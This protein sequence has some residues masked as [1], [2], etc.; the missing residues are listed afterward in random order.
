MPELKGPV[1]GKQSNNRAELT[2]ILEC[3]KACEGLSQNI[4]IFSD[5]QY[6][7]DIISKHCRA[8]ALGYMDQ[9]NRRNTLNLDL[10]DEIV[11]RILNPNTPSVFTSKVAAHTGIAGNERADQ[12]AKI[13][14]DEVWA[15]QDLNIINRRT[16]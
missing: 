1:V 8:N 7:I 15:R 2:A 6:S 13:A 4:H 14:V 11:E 10:I 12:L 16:A 5:S 9:L 3:I